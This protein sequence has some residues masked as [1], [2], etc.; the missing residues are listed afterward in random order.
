MNNLAVDFDAWSPLKSSSLPQVS[1]V[2]CLGVPSILELISRIN[3][4]QI[5]LTTIERT[6]CIESVP[7]IRLVRLIHLL[8]FFHIYSQC[9]KNKQT[10]TN[11]TH[12]DFKSMHDGSKYRDLQISSFN[13]DAVPILAKIRCVLF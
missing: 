6:F 8:V 5:Q 11:K 2:L 12:R 13:S 10:D 7:R 3:K 4:R 1:L 9:C